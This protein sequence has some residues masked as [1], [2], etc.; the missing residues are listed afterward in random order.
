[1]RGRVGQGLMLRLKDVCFSYDRP[2]SSKAVLKDIDLRVEAG[3]FLAVIG[4]T[5]SGKSTLLLHFNGLLKPNVGQ[6]LYQGQDIHRKGFDLRGLRRE[7]GLL[8]QFPEGNLFGQTVYEDVSY[9]PANYGISG[10]A[11]D[12]VVEAALQLAGLEAGFLLRSP[13]TLSGGE[14]RKVALAGVLALEPKVLLLDE[15]TA[16]LDPAARENFLNLLKGLNSQGITVIAITHDLEEVSRVAGRVVILAEGQVLADGP[17]REVLTR[18][19]LEKW[20]LETP[21][22]IRLGKALNLNVEGL[23]VIFEEEAVKTILAGRG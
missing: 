8:F 12:R 4:P 2:G 17:V 14:K 13:F 6:V 18:E 20:E 10:K 23:P 7:V 3:E 9:G 1:M 19:D 15:P 5:G 21:E 22:V 11:L 16:G